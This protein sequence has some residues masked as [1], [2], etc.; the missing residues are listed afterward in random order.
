VSAAVK[1]AFIDLCPW[2][3]DVGSP[4]VRPLGGSQSALSYLAI[5]LA[6]R[7]NE[8][9]VGNATTT[10]RVHLG[11][12]CCSLA[13][14]GGPAAFSDFDAVIVLNGPADASLHFRPALPPRCKLILWTQD[15]HDQPGMIALKQPEVRAAWDVIACVSLWHAGSMLRHYGLDPN[16]LVIQR[17]AVAPAFENLFPD[18]AAMI[19]AKSGP[20][21]MAYTSTPFR[22]L[23]A[24]LSLFPEVRR[25]DEQAR[26]RVYSSMKV[27]DQDESGDRYA[28]LYE[29]CRATPGAE[30]V[31]SVAQP[32]LAEALKPVAILAYPN[33]Y[34]ETS[35]IAAMEAMAAGLFVVTSDLGALPETTMGMAVTTPGPHDAG[36]LPAFM[37]AYAARLIAAM[38][39]SRQ[40]PQ[41]FWSNRWQQVQT[42]TTRCTWQVRAAEWE[43]ML[44]A[45]T[46]NMGTNRGPGGSVSTS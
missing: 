18:M 12:R 24:L 1:F 10:P 11:V 34:P 44:K 20:P 27:Y 36:E 40:D 23:R 19:A 16:R 2:D 7:G 33:I 29:R 25:Y 42:V 37:Q 5:A 45:R 13:T 21:L 15:A 17:N 3:Y 9:I 39:E 28:T 8:V 32:I 6:A 30:Y 35:C 4:F 22:G 46:L 41:R 43:E 31:G 14:T 38:K 26:L